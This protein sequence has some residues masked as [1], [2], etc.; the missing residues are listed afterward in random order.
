MKKIFS[1]FSSVALIASVFAYTGCSDNK[2]QSTNIEDAVIVRTQPVTVENY[3]KA[4]EYSGAIASAS[5]ARGT[6]LSPT[7][8]MVSTTAAVS[9]PALTPSPTVTSSTSTQTS[10]PPRFDFDLEHGTPMP[11]ETRGGKP[12]Y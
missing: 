3:A 1:S 9:A 12:A 2:A 5:E 4:L 11:P 8:T 7:K 6:Q 10:A